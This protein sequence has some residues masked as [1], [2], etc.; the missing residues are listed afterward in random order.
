MLGGSLGCGAECFGAS[1]I[2]GAQDLIVICFWSK[3]NSKNVL[4][5]NLKIILEKLC[6]SG[7]TTSISL[8]IDTFSHKLCPSSIQL[9]PEKFIEGLFS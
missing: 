8:L 7:E 6:L 3:S 5:S 9:V 1:S 2:R 4:G